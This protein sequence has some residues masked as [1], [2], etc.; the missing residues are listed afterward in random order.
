MTKTNNENKKNKKRIVVFLAG[1][2]ALALVVG[3]WAYYS[4]VHTISNGLKTATYEKYGSELVEKFTPE[5]DWK[6]GQTVAKEVEVKNTGDG[7]LYVRVKLDETWTFADGSNKPQFVMGSDVAD[8]F[9]A[10][11]SEG[12]ENG[13]VVYKEIVNDTKWIFDDASGYWY[14]KTKLLSGNSTDLLLKS[15]TLAQD[16]NLEG[17][18]TIVKYY[19]EADTQPNADNIGSDAETQWK[20]YTGIVPD[21]AKHVR[22][23]SAMDDV[24]YAGASYVLTITSDVVQATNDVLTE[25]AGLPDSVKTAWGISE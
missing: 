19:T 10:D 20:V 8:F 14:Y 5:I 2:A 11:S 9:P 4:A 12:V 23:V 3:V 7:D 21:G 15:I 6:A 13:S 24:E 18:Y 16:T 1:L 25:W 17:D 22:S